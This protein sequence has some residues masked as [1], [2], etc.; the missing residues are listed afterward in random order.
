LLIALDKLVATAKRHY[1]HG[2]LERAL[3][4]CALEI[5]GTGGVDG[6]TL[7]RVGAKAGVSRSALYRHFDDKAA[8]VTR[9]ATDGFRL[10]HE[11]LRRVRAN[12]TR[13]GRD[14][15]E[16]MA[17]AHVH[18]AQANP[19]HY[20]T[21]FGGFVGDTQSRPGF[22][23]SAEAALGEVVDAVRDAQSRGNLGAGDPVPIAEVMWALT[24]GV[25]RL[26]RSTPLTPSAVPI[27]ALA[28]QG[29]RWVSDGC[30]TPI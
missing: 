16:V 26:R 10:L 6:L 9:I 5:I 25:A 11:T 21:M 29:V 30:Q 17:A 15:L 27:E 13:D 4:A 23:R 2:D 3:V 12:A 28:V 7:R 14:T 1:H 24:V 20:A 19:S 8:L 22:V 18:F